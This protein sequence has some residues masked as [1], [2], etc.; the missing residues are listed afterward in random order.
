MAARSVD[1]HAVDGMHTSSSGYVSSPANGMA[2]MS[3]SSGIRKVSAED[4]PSQ[5]QQLQQIRRARSV[6]PRDEQASAAGGTAAAS[7]MNHVGVGGVRCEVGNSSPSAIAASGSG[8]VDMVNGMRDGLK[9]YTTATGAES[10]VAAAPAGSRGGGGGNP[11]VAAANAM[12]LNEERLLR[13]MEMGFDQVGATT[14]LPAYVVCKRGRVPLRV[15]LYVCAT[16]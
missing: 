14:A 11:G 6:E 9:Q 5:H 7:T 4:G 3:A 15:Y 13:L 16:S 1:R 8:R 2:S 10:L 12:H